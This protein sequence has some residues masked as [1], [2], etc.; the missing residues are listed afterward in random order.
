MKRILQEIYDW[1]RLKWPFAKIIN[2]FIGR[3]RAF[4]IRAAVACER[5]LGEIPKDNE[6]GY[7]VAT[8]IFAG[9]KW[10]RQTLVGSEFAPKILG[11]YELEL[12]ELFRDLLIDQELTAFVDIGA[13]EGYYAVGAAV[14]RKDFQVFAY[15][16]QDRAHEEIRKLA[17]VNG[18]E[19]SLHVRS[20]FRNEELDALEFGSK[21]LVLVDIE[22][23][24]EELVD[25]RFLALFAKAPILI[26]VHDFIIPGVGERLRE[27]L[28]MTHIV[29]RIDY[30]QNERYRH[31]QGSRLKKLDWE[32]ATDEKR[33]RRLNYWL[34]AIPKTQG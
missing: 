11:T 4:R 22:G 1:L 32:L 26:E 6:G 24:E 9:M 21:P 7:V 27:R 23:A 20:T 15:E 13:A 17:E 19:K 2:F 25:E 10:P 12:Q 29:R 30:R 8:G 14:L 33:V 18:V 28:N 5:A 31:R 16:I 3:E 34:V